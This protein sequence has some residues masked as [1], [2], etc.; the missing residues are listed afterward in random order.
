MT[1]INK[2]F[3]FSKDGEDTYFE[4]VKKFPLRSIK[5]DSELGRAQLILDELFEY[6]PLNEGEEAYL[7][8]LSDLIEHYEEHNVH[9]PVASD[10][11]VLRHLMES[12]D[13]NQREFAERIDVPKSVVCDVLKGRRKFTRHQLD[14]VAKFFSISKDIFSSGD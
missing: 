7:D 10:A 12:H 9:L 5:G 14:N 13:L 11:D 6:E 2:R 4:L 8:A 1:T 3:Q